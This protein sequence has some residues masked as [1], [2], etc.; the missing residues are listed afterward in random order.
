LLTKSLAGGGDQRLVAAKCL[1]ALEINAG[2]RPGPYRDEDADQYAHHVLMT[3]APG[4][5]VRRG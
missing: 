3:C 4:W 1:Y 2:D 5:P